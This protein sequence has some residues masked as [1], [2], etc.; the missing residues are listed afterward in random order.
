[1]SLFLAR[2]AALVAALFLSSTGMT[3][4]EPGVFRP[5]Y[6]PAPAD[7]PLQTG[8][9]LRFANADA[10]PLRAGWLTLGKIVIP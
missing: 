2:T 8:R 5:A 6:A 9:P 4:A 1:M 3:A 10:E 7:N